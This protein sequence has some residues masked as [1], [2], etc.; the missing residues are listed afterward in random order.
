[1]HRKIEKQGNILLCYDT[2]IKRWAQFRSTF[3]EN[4]KKSNYIKEIFNSE[5]QMKNEDN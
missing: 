2:Y 1:M 5:S 4:L 3:R